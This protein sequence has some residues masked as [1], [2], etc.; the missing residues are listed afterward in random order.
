[1]NIR[2]IYPDQQARLR[3]FVQSDTFRE[4]AL[5][6]IVGGSGAVLNVALNVLF[7]KSGIRPSISLALTLIVLAPPVYYCQHRLTF[8]SKADHWS[9]FP[10]YFGAQLF[11]IVI[12]MGIAEVI[13]APIKAHPTVAYV[14]ITALVAALNYG[15]LKFWA[16]RH[17]SAPAE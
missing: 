15:I 9:A 3:R 17:H 12:A 7:T 10:R 8:R 1:M 2:S 11:G 4:V 5:F 6:L 14:L 16:F 13:P